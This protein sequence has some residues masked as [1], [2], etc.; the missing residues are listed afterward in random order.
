MYYRLARHASFQESQRVINVVHKK[1]KRRSKHEMGVAKREEPLPSTGTGRSVGA[2]RSLFTRS[3]SVCESVSSLKRHLSEDS[4]TGRQP[5]KKSE[6]AC[7]NTKKIH[8]LKEGLYSH[9][10]FELISLLLSVHVCLF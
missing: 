7:T 2:C 1:K 6:Y 10:Q 8:C 9:I 4:D 3:H 5:K